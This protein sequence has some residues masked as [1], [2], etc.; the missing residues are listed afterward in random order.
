M[1][2]GFPPGGGAAATWVADSELD[3]G[4]LSQAL[5]RHKWRILIPTI[6]AAVGAFVVV[7]TLTTRYASDARVLIDVRENVFLRPEAERT[8]PER[9]AFDEQAIASQ[10]QIFLSRDLAREVIT[11]L[12]LG[13][14]PEFDPMLK[15]LSPTSRVLAFLGLAKD[16][17]KMS[18]EERVLQSYYDGLTVF[19]VDKSRVIEVSFQSTDSDLAAKVA[20]AV[21]DG[22]LAL[23]QQAKQDQAR[24]ASQW[25]SGEI[26]TLRKR[27]A[28]AEARAAEFR[29]RANL[30]VN[31]NNASLANQQ[32]TDL[33]AQLATARTQKADAE[34]RS[35]LI[36]NILTSG[37]PIE[38]GDAIDSELIRRLSEQ[39]VT[40]MAQLAEQSATLLGGHP[41]IR[42]L[43]AQLADLNQEIRNEAERRVRALENESRIA[44]ARV[45]SLSTSLDQLK[46]LAGS[47]N[48]L[49]VQMRAL[50]REA[51]AQRDLLESYLAKYREAAA[52]DS[53]SAAPA[54]ARIISRAT[55]SNVPVFPKRVPMILV[56][57]ML[58]LMLGIGFVATRE[59]LSPQ[60]VRPVGRELGSSLAA[61]AALPGRTSRSSVR[62]ADGGSSAPVPVGAIE[63]LARALRQAGEVGRRVTVLGAARNVGTSFAAIMLARALARDA[64]VVL[65]DLALGAPNLAVISTDPNAPGI[66]ELVAGSATVTDV[67]TRDQMSSVHVIAAGQG[68]KTPASV[69]NS[70][71]LAT[72]I[73]ALARSYDHVI[74]DGG[75][76]PEIA[77]ERFAELSQTGVLVVV[78]PSHRGA[79]SA[80]QR[81]QAV[82]FAEVT[83]LVA[84]GSTG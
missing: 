67:I 79:I 13:D 82:G 51:K 39:R 66:V 22:Y 53:I 50:E 30:F 58:T 27:V 29:S 12:K 37:R 11:K 41:R 46:R 5:W 20:N 71:R 28:D 84:N 65:I 83:M 32:L 26:E 76:L 33:N 23:Q 73:E 75:A 8:T 1:R 81:L 49:D 14:R 34:A 48:E 64:R 60:N 36:R 16:P 69:L 31:T 74:M 21:A 63:E 3:L 42:E 15:G 40:L 9:T 54:D 70:S 7:N 72:T 57:T 55:V 59:L 52:R 43:R 4:A 17:L 38:A 35:R 10:I 77:A 6:A 44:G 45:E 56:A 47:S 24:S 80:C 78:D 25:L 68:V 2:G 19:S 18:A 62:V 61:P